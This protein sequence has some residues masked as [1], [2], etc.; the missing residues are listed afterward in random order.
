MRVNDAEVGVAAVTSTAIIMGQDLRQ[1]LAL[2]LID[3]RKQLAAVEREADRFR[4]GEP[5]DGDFVCPN[6]YRAYM[7]EK[8]CDALRMALKQI[9]SG[10]GTLVGRDDDGL[11]CG[12]CGKRGI[13]N[14]HF[15]SCPVAIAR[16]ALKGL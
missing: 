16:A 6:D 2:D 9:A 7:A 8:D 5:V 10:D 4:H 14:D 15:G 11:F 12:A 1:D 13:G 3:A